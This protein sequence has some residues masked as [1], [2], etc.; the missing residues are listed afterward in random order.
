MPKWSQLKMAHAEKKHKLDIDTLIRC[1]NKTFVFSAGLPRIT[2]KGML[3]MCNM[4][5]NIDDGEGRDNIME[6]SIR[7]A[8]PLTSAKTKS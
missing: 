4:R 8:T 7:L 6:L 2:R 1:I 3:V 5:G